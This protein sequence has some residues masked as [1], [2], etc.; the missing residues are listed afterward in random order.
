MENISK[1]QI[2]KMSTF[3]LLSAVIQTFSLT[4]FSMVARIYPSGITGLSRFVSDILQDFASISLPFYYLYILINILLA[5]L[6]YK[7]IGKLFTI[8]SLI[9]TLLVSVFS[10]FF[11]TLTV[12]EDTMLLAIFGGLINGFGVS[13]ALSVGASSGG[14]DFIS[15]YYSNKYH[16]SMWNYVFAFNCSILFLTGLLYGWE[17]AAYSMIF[18]FVSNYVIS[19]RHKRYTHQAIIIITRKPDEVIKAILDNVRHGITRIQARGAYN[20]DDQTI[21]YTVVNTF[22]TAEVIRYALQ[23]DPKAFI[24]TRNTVSV[25]GNYYQKPLD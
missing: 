23:G 17:R 10:S 14:T 2:L 21:L 11:P 18:Q 13:L 15:I 5:A 20:N 6:V 1:K 4:S 9:Q 12:L 8:F 7:H 19:H 3:V 24:E 22:Q 25:H 16:R